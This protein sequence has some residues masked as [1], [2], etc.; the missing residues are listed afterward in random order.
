MDC[1]NGTVLV[2]EVLVKCIATESPDKAL[3]SH[4]ADVINHLKVAGMP[5]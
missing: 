5:T 4:K 1:I 2:L 3:I